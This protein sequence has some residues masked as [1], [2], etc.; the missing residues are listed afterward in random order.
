MEVQLL[1]RR[2]SA[3]RAVTAIALAAVL[4]VA[5]AVTPSFAGSILTPKR[6]ARLYLSN[7]QATGLYLKK[8][9]A[10][11]LFVAK[12]TAPLT[13][14]VAIAASNTAFGPVSATAAT[15]IPTAFTSFA[16]KGV[17][18]AVITF[19]GQA[20]CTSPTAAIVACPV[21]ILVDG[22][23]AAKVNF[24]TSTTGSPAAASEVHTATVT[25]V[26]GKGGHTVS[27]QYAGTPTKNNA[28]P[29]VA[30]GLTSWNL[31][32]QAY[33]QAPEAEETSPRKPGSSNGSG[34]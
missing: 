15:G 21:S 7:R 33:P 16:T 3:P 27:I 30:F 28:A 2:L 20:T 14:I 12:A 23:T 29:T 9:T 31:A 26:L 22:L 19:S 25:T 13:P 10:A 34:K 24:A 11:N 6:A 17:G 32:V 4:A 8:K 18:S 1:S 5:L